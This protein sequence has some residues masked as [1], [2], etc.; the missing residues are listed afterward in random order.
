MKT[1]GIWVIVFMYYFYGSSTENCP[2]FKVRPLN[3]KD[4]QTQYWKIYLYLD[5]VKI[6]Q[7]LPFFIPHECYRDWP[8]IYYSM[9]DQVENVEGSESNEIIYNDLYPQ[10]CS[11]ESLTA[12]K[13]LIDTDY[14]DFV[15]LYRCEV[16]WSKEIIQ[17]I[18]ILKSSKSNKFHPTSSL[19][20]SF[21]TMKNQLNISSSM[22]N[23][24]EF[25]IDRSGDIENKAKLCNF[26]VIKTSEEEYYDESGKFI[27]LYLSYI[28][29]AQIVIYFAAFGAYMVKSYFTDDCDTEKK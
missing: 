21:I 18:I 26:S 17:S 22:L 20:Y 5:P 24:E 15:T 2:S 11:L 23:N 9:F 3:I 4:I 10:V 14:K 1:L 25:I 16:S 28:L 8:N 7:E 29:M 13:Y 6:L 27:Q 12:P 19:K